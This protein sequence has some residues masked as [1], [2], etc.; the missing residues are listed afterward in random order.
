MDFSPSKTDT[1][2][3]KEEKP[4]LSKTT[5]PDVN[6]LQNFIFIPQQ[7][8]DEKLRPKS[9][10]LSPSLP[11]KAYPVLPNFANNKKP[12]DKI[13]P[14][15]VFPSKTREIKNGFNKVSYPSLSP[16]SHNKLEIRE[17]PKT[18]RGD[19][20]QTQKMSIENGTKGLNL[21]NENFEQRKS[22]SI[23]HPQKSILDT[24]D[25]DFL[26]I[27][28][29]RADFYKWISCAKF[30][31]LYDSERP[32]PITKSCSQDFFE[33]VYN[34]PKCAFFV[35]CDECVFGFYSES[36]TL[37]LSPLDFLFG[38]KATARSVNKRPNRFFVPQF[39]Q[40]VLFTLFGE[41]QNRSERG[42][43]LF[44]LEVGYKNVLSVRQKEDKSFQREIGKHFV[45][46]AK[47]VNLESFLPS[48]W[49]FV[50]RRVICITFK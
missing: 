28:N 40:N 41:K 11:V 10:S 2:E 20:K 49:D 7:Q 14:P 21:L 37:Y 36:Q 16:P 4:L 29:C 22:P 15:P 39:S 46:R 31:V 35:F 34:I 17:I 13:S 30:E 1:K 12:I 6:N 42:R 18:T 5:P 48:T 44:A 24:T 50:V 9:N 25:V 19:E 3:T 38:I 23:Q 47:R 8:K 26:V 43:D 33:K 45:D 32:I 27:E